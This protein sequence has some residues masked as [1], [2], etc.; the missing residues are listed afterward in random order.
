MKR[1]RTVVSAIVLGS[2]AVVPPV[3][4][5]QGY[6]ERRWIGANS[7]QYEQFG[8]AVAF[9]DY[10]NDGKEDL[11]VGNPWG[12]RVSSLPGSG[13]VMLY[14]HASGPVVG[15]GLRLWQGV[16]P[17]DLPESGD[18]FGTA[19]AFG[20]FNGD[21]FDDLA[22]GV[23]NEDVGP[24]AAAGAVQVFYGNPARAVQRTTVFFQGLV[25]QDPQV[26]AVDRFGQ[27]LAVGDFNGDGF[28][29]LAVGA[30][31]E[32]VGTASNAG[33]VTVFYGYANGLDAGLPRQLWTQASN[34]IEGTPETDDRFGHSLAAG[35]LNADGRDDLVIG[36]PF[37]D[38]SDDANAGAVHV[39]YGTPVALNA[40]GSQ[41]WHQNRAGLAVP[42]GST[43][44]DAAEPHEL[45]GYAVAVGDLN[46]DGYPDL[47]VG[48]P[49]EDRAQTGGRAIGV[50][51]VHVFQG[52]P[53]GVIMGGNVFWNYPFNLNAGDNF[54]YSLA[55][56]DLNED[57]I[58]DL[59]VGM[60]FDDVY[61][62]R[63]GY[64]NTWRDA[65]SVRIVWGY[66]PGS[67]GPRFEAFWDEVFQNNG[68]WDGDDYEYSEADDWFGYAIAVGHFG[69]QD[70]QPYLAVGIPGEEYSTWVNAG[71]VELRWGTT[72]TP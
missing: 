72:R 34:G 6:L 4:E 11:A 9:G 50:G 63:N 71:A 67:T 60:P 64:G 14:F 57:G 39:L 32:G 12:T 46:G 25:P 65:G 35:D 42:T 24:L 10:D 48:A 52:S 38:L 54:G 33:S 20:D 22:V 66:R 21:G 1:T 41:L 56:G 27:T 58:D 49:G 19:L 51:S 45:F 18:N 69:G 2:V 3:V 37:E 5:A 47:A 36:V 53:P 31:E 44:P 7:R 59:V 55:F 17:V 68:S 16:I 13:E 70:R 26:E 40:S 8:R 43:Q 29:D 28:D 30:E 62:V 23:P 61:V 15:S